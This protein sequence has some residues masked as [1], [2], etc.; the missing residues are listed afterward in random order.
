VDVDGSSETIT[1]NELELRLLDEDDYERATDEAR[2]E[3][4]NAVQNMLADGQPDTMEGLARSAASRPNALLASSSGKSVQDRPLRLPS[5]SF[6]AN[7]REDPNPRTFESIHEE[8]DNRVPIIPSGVGAQQLQDDDGDGIPE[9][10]DL[11]ACTGGQVTNCSDNCPFVENPDQADEDLDRIGDACEGDPDGDGVDSDGDGS[12][13]EGDAPCDSVA[14]EDCDDNCPNVPNPR[15]WD[16]DDDGIGDVCDTDRDGNGIADLDEGSVD[17]D[18]DGVPTED[19]GDVD[20]DGDGSPDYLDPDDDGDGIPSAQENEGEQGIDPDLDSDDDG[21][22]DSRDSDSDGD[23]ISDGNEGTRDTD[24]D[25]VPD[26]KDSDDDGDGTP[27]ADEYDGDDQDTDGDGIPNHLDGN[28][29]DGCSERKLGARYQT[30]PT[31]NG[32]TFWTAWTAGVSTLAGPCVVTDAYSSC[33]LADYTWAIH[34]AEDGIYFSLQTSQGNAIPPDLAG[35]SISE[36]FGSMYSTDPDPAFISADTMSN[37]QNLSIAYEVLGFFQGWT[38]LEG[39][40]GGFFPPGRFMQ[41]DVGVG[42]SIGLLDI[43]GLAFLPSISVAVTDGGITIKDGQGEGA[44]SAFILI[45]GWGDRCP[46]EGSQPAVQA[47]QAGG[48]SPALAT[49]RDRVNAAATTTPTSVDSSYRQDVG[50]A[51]APMLDMMTTTTGFGS[52]QNVPAPSVGDWFGE[53]TSRETGEACT[54]CVNMSIDGIITRTGQ[55]ASASN[56]S[57]SEL[58]GRAREQAGQFLNAWPERERM[59]SLMNVAAGG[60]INA[61]TELAYSVAAVRRGEPYRFVSEQIVDVPVTINES[62]EFTVTAQEIADLVGFP[63]A[64][65]EG[66]TVCVENN[67]KVDRVCG[68]IEG[69]E[70]TGSITPDSP[71][72]WILPVTVNLSTAVGRFGDANVEAWT[73]RPAVRRFLVDP[74][75]ASRAVLAAPGTIKSGAPVTLNVTTVSEDGYVTQGQAEFRL[76]DG[77]GTLLETKTAEGGAATFQIQPTPKTPSIAE[78]RTQTVGVG[79]EDVPGYVI[80]GELISRDATIL[81]DGRDVDDIGYLYTVQDSK[82]VGIAVVEGTSELSSGSH[83]FE[84]QNPG[85]ESSGEFPVDL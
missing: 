69:G 21:I 81:I 13:T 34:S 15:Q 39:P 32:F 1:S 30:I 14:V 80:D 41:M 54:N 28:P 31:F 84:V 23:G 38:I 46:G 35:F 29:D 27:T 65:I 2:E 85:G 36:S 49:Y 63:A 16:V 45:G 26:S 18:N 42:F 25:G 24:G 70:L 78:V 67:P 82:S 52:A 7:E 6:G 55:A 20:S 17:H 60:S 61:G 5:I 10:P 37:G 11:A 48:P 19:E 43:F 33:G 12:G 44:P 50:S 59:A 77:T 58:T 8:L 57:V 40:G 22:P 75:P 83:T 56:G 64:D 4:A 72:P 73:V 47:K 71:E 51:M 68:T 53:F 79:G 66:A 3:T 76:Y 74:G 9:D 62:A